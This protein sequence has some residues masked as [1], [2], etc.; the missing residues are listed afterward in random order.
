MLK[1]EGIRRGLEVIL[2]P[3]FANIEDIKQKDKVV[4]E[5]SSFQLMTMNVHIDCALITNITP[6]HLDI[7]KDMEEYTEAKKNIFKFQEEKDL[8]S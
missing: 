5:L 3:L 2:N 1:T 7:H 6:N 4:L 8:L